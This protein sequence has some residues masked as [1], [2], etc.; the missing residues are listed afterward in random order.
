MKKNK[1]EMR[2]TTKTSLAEVNELSTSQYSRLP[3]SGGLSDEEMARPGGA[4]MAAL[5]QTAN[6][7][8]HTMK[9]MA[10]EL[11]VTYGYISQMRNGIRL[12]SYI[13]DKFALDVSKYLGVPRLTVLMMAGQITTSDI[14]ASEQMKASQIAQAMSFIAQDIKWAP[15]LTL[16]LRQSSLESQYLLIRLFEKAT[17][18][19]LLDEHLDLRA[20]T[21][22]VDRVVGLRAERKARPV[23]PEPPDDSSFLSS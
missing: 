7:R 19:V 21:V 10:E 20:L 9:K 6:E 3:W 8:R 5:V 16:E 1:T 2:A 22:E 14:F 11:G 17:G 13:S 15:F 4:L 12:V 23:A 18:R